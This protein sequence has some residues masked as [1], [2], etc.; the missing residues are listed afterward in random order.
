MLTRTRLYRLTG[1]S[2]IVAVVL[3]ALG[4]HVITRWTSQKGL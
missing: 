3:A 2:W 1:R 4:A